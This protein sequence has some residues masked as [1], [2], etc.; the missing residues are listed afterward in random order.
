MSLDYPQVHTTPH[1]T[2][3]R[4]EQPSRPRAGTDA[5]RVG[6]PDVADPVTMAHNA[7]AFDDAIQERV[8][9]I[10]ALQG[11]PSSG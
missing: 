4:R 6:Q 7:L 3:S 11:L 10:R 8:R 2:P 1:P 5:Y 9:I